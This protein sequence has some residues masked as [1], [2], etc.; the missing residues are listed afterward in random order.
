MRQESQL[1][2]LVIARKLAE[3][4]GM[5]PDLC[6]GLRHQHLHGY[7]AYKGGLRLWDGDHL[8]AIEKA[9]PLINSLITR[10][11]SAWLIFPKE[12][13]VDLQNK[14]IKEQIPT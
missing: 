13:D 11:D 2:I 14:L 3:K 6:C 5:D 8:R 7:H 4:E 1:D 9:S 10:A 12:I